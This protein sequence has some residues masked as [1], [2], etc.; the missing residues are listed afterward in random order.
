VVADVS[1]TGYPQVIQEQSVTGDFQK[2]YLWG[3]DFLRQDT[4]VFDRNPF[5]A[6]APR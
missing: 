1:P 2:A 3:L 4:L 5:C 6:D